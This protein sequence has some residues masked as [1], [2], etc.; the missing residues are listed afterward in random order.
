[1][2]DLSA[3]RLGEEGAFGIRILGTELLIGCRPSTQEAQVLPPA[4][5]KTI[6]RKYQVRNKEK[7]QA[8]SKAPFRCGLRVQGGVLPCAV[9]LRHP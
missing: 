9:S 3:P 5:G 4:L 1:M 6:E 8:D 7:T 2:R